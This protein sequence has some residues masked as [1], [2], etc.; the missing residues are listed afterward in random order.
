MITISENAKE[1]IQKL[2][3]ETNLDESY[4]LRVGGVV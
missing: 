3:S 2:M 4:F 1:Q